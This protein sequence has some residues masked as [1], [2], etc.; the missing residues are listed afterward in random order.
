[1][2][3]VERFRRRDLPHWD[4]PGATYFVTACLAG[5]IPAQ[6]LLDIQTYQAE[7]QKTQR[8]AEI[9]TEAWKTRTWKLTFARI[10]QWL[11]HSSAVRY[12]QDQRLART[13]L[14]TLLH[15][16]GERYD[17][18]GFAIMPSHFHWVFRPLESW[19]TSLTGPRSPRERIMQSIKSYSARQCNDL[20]NREGA[21]WQEE[22]YDHW[23]RDMD[24]LERVIHYVENNP[25]NA[26]LVE[27]PERW[28]FSSA[29]LR[30]QQR[31]EFGMPLHGS[32]P[33]G[34]P[35]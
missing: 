32:R 1:M 10:D 14:S 18:I 19:V 33:P 23:V 29:S 9:S 11:D 17:V 13:V 5:S 7:Q 6:G 3:D 24:E 8:P 34:L 21:F 28:E 22:S 15:F 25:V 30:N 2:Q 4:M 16:A 31:L 27:S 12:L 35:R 26:G 20:L